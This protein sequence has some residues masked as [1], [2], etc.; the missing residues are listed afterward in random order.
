M[1][2]LEEHVCQ[3]Y[4]LS[5]AI[6]RL[7]GLRWWIL[8]LKQAESNKLPPSKAAFL[9][10][11]KWSKYQC[12]ICKSV[13]EPHPKIPLPEKHGWKR[14]GDIYVSVVTALPPAPETILQLVKYGCNKTPCGTGRYKC[15]SNKL[16]CTGLC[17][18]GAEDDSCKKIAV[19]CNGADY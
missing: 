6:S 17:C 18:C 16:Y 11:V 3:L 8:R 10:S 9:Q 15:R 2:A 1:G 14:E 13:V 12:I 7:N 5:T 19:D 4:Q